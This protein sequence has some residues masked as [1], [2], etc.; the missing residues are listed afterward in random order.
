MKTKTK[1][2]SY[3]TMKNGEEKKTEIKKK[4]ET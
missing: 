1:T 2:K 3:R 4:G